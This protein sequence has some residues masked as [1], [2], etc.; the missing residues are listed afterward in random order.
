MSKRIAMLFPYAPAYRELIYKKIDEEFEVDWFFCGNAKRSLKL[1]DYSLFKRCNTSMI[2]R[3]LFGPIHKYEGIRKLDLDQYEVIIVPTVTR[4][5]SLWWLAYHYGKKKKGPKLY[6]W[7]HG[8][9]GREKRFEKFLKRL[10]YSKADGFF[11]YNNG[12]KDIMKRMGYDESKLHVIY[13]S[14]NYDIQMK[15]RL[16]MEPSRLYQDHFGNNNKNVVFIGRLR[17]IKKFDLLINAVAI[18]KQRG[19]FIN[20]TFIGDGEERKNLETIVEEKGIKDKVWFYGACYDER[21]SAELIYNADLCVSPGHI[22]LTAMHVMMF[23]C[24]AITSNDMIHQ[25]PEV[26]AVVVGKTGAFFKSDDS[27]S[28]AECIISWFAAHSN[29]RDRI[30]QNCYDEIDAHWNPDYQVSVIKKAL[31]L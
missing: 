2:E 25:T 26:E 3:Q 27:I 28:L 17:K 8:W 29:D 24:P 12:A 5:T 6:Y 18:L 11:L 20:V 31:Y 7:T 10:Y 30:R 16:S 22:G 15:V 13:N 23:G 1:L 9:Y 14:L 4:C 21:I 19:F